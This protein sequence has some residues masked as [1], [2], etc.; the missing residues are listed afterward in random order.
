[1]SLPPRLQINQCKLDYM[2]LILVIYVNM[3]FFCRNDALILLGK[4]FF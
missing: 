3:N 1:M 4:D 2:Y